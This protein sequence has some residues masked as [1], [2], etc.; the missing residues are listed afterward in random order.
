M[1]GFLI[2]LL[3]VWELALPGFRFLGEVSSAYIIVLLVSIRPDGFRCCAKLA[4]DSLL[5]SP[6]TMISLRDSGNGAG[7][8]PKLSR[9]RV[10]ARS[11][12]AQTRLD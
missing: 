9:Q 4:G 5:N 3:K 12:A 10:D 2:P 6:G 8:H 7:R 1:V 11:R